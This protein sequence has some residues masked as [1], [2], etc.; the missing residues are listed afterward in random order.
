MIT[1]VDIEADVRRTLAEDVG[2]GDK[3]ADLI[4]KAS[5]AT[6]HVYLREPAT[7]CGQPWFNEVF[8]QIDSSVTIDWHVEEGQQV[9]A[10][11]KI[12]TLKG[13]ARALLTGERSALNFLQTLSGTATATAQYVAEIAHTQCRLLDTRKTIPGM[14]LAQKY[15]VA[16][17]KGH[18]HRIGLFDAIL[19]K[20]N[21]ILAAGSITAAVANARTLHPSV[22]VEVEVENFEELTEA[23]AAKPDVIMLDN[24]SVANITDAVR[25]VNG[26]VELEASGDISLS[27]IRQFA[28]TGVTYISVGAI[29][30][31][32]HAIDLS[33]RIGFDSADIQTEIL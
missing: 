27:T 24:F 5:Q 30:K 4:P 10:E 16:T 1:A 9:G 33:M 3:T 21:H 19:I 29:T 6:A 11:T 22:K 12:A 23:L 15:A 18:N 28:E 2:S 13:N 8:N 25:S 31:H 17:G 32:I 26:A 7:I 20:E 14:R